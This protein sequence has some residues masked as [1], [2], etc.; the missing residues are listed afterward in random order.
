MADIQKDAVEEAAHGLSGTNKR[1]TS[2][3]GV[4]GCA[5]PIYA[6]RL[7]RSGPDVNDD[8]AGPEPIIGSTSFVACARAE[9]TH[10]QITEFAR[11]SLLEEAVM[12]EPVS[13]GQIPGIYREF[14]ALNVYQLAE[15]RRT[16]AR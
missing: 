7:T 12:S 4:T 16:R 15:R 6:K 14:R 8:T 2:T 9:V 3:R 11:D 13:D 10:F 5:T 1:A